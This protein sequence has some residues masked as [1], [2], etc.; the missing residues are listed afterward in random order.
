MKKTLITVALSVLLTLG[1]LS[2]G[3]A[4]AFDGYSDSKYIPAL[5]VFPRGSIGLSMTF[6][7]G[8][9][10]YLSWGM[11][12]SF[13]PLSSLENQ[14]MDYSAL[15]LFRLHSTNLWQISERLD[16]HFSL[17]LGYIEVVPMLGVTYMLGEKIGFESVLVVPAYYNHPK[18][19]LTDESAYRKPYLAFGI[20][21]NG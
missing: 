8:I 3:R 17:G 5:Q 11:M 12:A 4:Q 16:M 9:N 21:I 19:I 7:E 6:Q 18:K 1:T 13:D 20:V 10:D 15:L 14:N 2:S